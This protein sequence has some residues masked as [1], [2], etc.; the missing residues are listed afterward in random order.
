[1]RSQ[2]EPAALEV[3]P[4]ESDADAIRR[5]RTDPDAFAAVFDRHFA[6]VHRYLHRRLGR[7]LADDLTAEVFMQAYRRRSVYD[8]RFESALPWL[9]G[10]AA[11][12]VRRQRRTETRR[13]RAYARS[14]VDEWAELDE[15]HVAE[16]V[17]AD[18]LGAHL[19]DALASLSAEDRETLTLV[20]LAD[21]TYEEVGR[22]LGVPTGTVASRM[23]R[24][25]SRLASRL[26][27]VPTK[28]EA[29]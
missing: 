21:L 22:A 28:E 12:L 10:V 3:A 18:R 14:G 20:V 13:L 11:N 24:I 5:S 9:Y 26:P 27:V 16:R 6:T 19:A 15:T 4:R 1:M 29:S 7:D 23:N 8:T 25:R 2:V 17:D